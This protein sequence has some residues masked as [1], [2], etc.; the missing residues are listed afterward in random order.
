M[1]SKNQKKF[2]ESLRSN[3]GVV[4][5]AAYACNMHRNSHFNW[6]R[7]S[8]EY[9]EEVEAVENECLDLAE[10]ALLTEIQN[11]NIA[12][13]IF[14]LKTKGKKRG[15]IEKQ[16][17]EYKETPQVIISAFDEGERNN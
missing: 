6:L 9:K 7:N 10:D 4:S 1:I 5:K 16:E 11:R 13:I 17:I 12:A 3:L 14:Y 8:A 2:L 15:Y